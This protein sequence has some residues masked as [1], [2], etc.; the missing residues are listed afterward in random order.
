M[1]FQADLVLMRDPSQ[2]PDHAGLLSV[3]LLERPR[4]SSKPP[5][6]IRARAVRRTNY[7]GSPMLQSCHTLAWRRS[8]SWLYVEIRASRPKKDNARGIMSE[9]KRVPHHGN[10]YGWD[11]GSVELVSA[12]KMGFGT[13]DSGKPSPA[14]CSFSPAHQVREGS[15]ILGAIR[16]CW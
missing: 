6:I 14:A 3:P 13:S 11:V 2:S 7:K 5:P 9:L 4:D 15:R 10:S 8:I 16:A 12:S 1:Q